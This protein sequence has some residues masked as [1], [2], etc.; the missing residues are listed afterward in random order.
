MECQIII[1]LIEFN[2]QNTQKQK[3]R[4]RNIADTAFLY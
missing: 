2:G 3:S 4:V 1:E